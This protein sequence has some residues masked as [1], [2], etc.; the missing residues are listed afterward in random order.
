M[1]NTKRTP[2]N[3]LIFAALVALLAITFIT[4]SS[5]GDGEENKKSNVT[6]YAIGDTGPGGGIVFYDKGSVSGGWRY[7]EAAPSNQVTSVTWSSTN[8]NVTGATGTAIGTGKA[9]TAAIIAA[10]SGDTASNNAAKAAVAY[11][12][13]GIT[14]WF[15]PSKDELNAMY[16]ARSHLGNSSGYFWSSSQLS[17]DY[18]WS[19]IFLYGVHGNDYK[20]NDL[21]VRPIRAF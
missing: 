7:L 5:C 13:G 17:S 11:N 6:T 19:Q 18:A 20:N 2:A 8:V 3:R 12:G 4:F 1:K 10:H 9:N 16:E 14:D 21:D 15:L